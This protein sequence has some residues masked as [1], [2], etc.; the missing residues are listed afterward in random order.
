[1]PQVI[2]SVAW[3]VPTSFHGMPVLDYRGPGAQLLVENEDGKIIQYSQTF[4]IFWSRL[5]DCQVR[6]DSR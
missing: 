2:D 6:R 1:M 5:K 3:M 4:R